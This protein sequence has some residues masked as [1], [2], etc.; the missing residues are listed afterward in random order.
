MSPIRF[1]IVGT[2]GF[3][4][5]RLGNLLPLHGVKVVGL[6][7]PDTSQIHRTREAHPSLMDVPAFEGIE[8][9]LSLE[10][11]AVCIMTPHTQ[12]VWQVEAGFAAGAH[13]LVE[14]PL[15][16]TIADC[17][18][19][20]RA[21]DAAGKVGMVSYQRHGLGIFRELRAICL[22]NRLGRLLMF[23][24]HLAQDW[25]RATRGTWRQVPEESGGGQINDSGSHMIDIL[26]WATGLEPGRVSAFMDNRGS[27]VDINSVV[28]IE[29]QSGALGSLTIIGDAPMWQERHAFW[30]EEGIVFLQDETLTIHDRTG[31]RTTI[32]QWPKADTPDANF[33][34]AIRGEAEVMSPFECGLATIR[35]TEMAWKSAET[36]APVNA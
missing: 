5:Y 13:V 25:L 27:D 21:R 15:S 4:R 14:K 28:N 16:T 17:E 9:G 3:A 32:D 20:I 29:F 36:S 2:G 33:V 18:R 12:H 35:L 8:Q 24:S 23:N 34:A 11:D 1:L 19:C 6:A 26:M 10:P 22:E 31:R 7:D 30:F